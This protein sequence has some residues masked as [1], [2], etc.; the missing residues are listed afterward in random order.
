MRADSVFALVSL[1]LNRART[2]RR[3][4]LRPGL[5]LSS[6]YMRHRKSG[7][8][9]TIQT[10]SGFKQSPASKSMAVSFT[11]NSQLLGGKMK[12]IIVNGFFAQMNE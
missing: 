5:G 12:V 7:W 4:G 6:L 10:V 9:A 11:F 2:K 8:G 1:F 3:L